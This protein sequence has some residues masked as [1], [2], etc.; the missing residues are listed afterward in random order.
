VRPLGVTMVH[1]ASIVKAI[2][3]ASATVLRG[4]DLSL[5]T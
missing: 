5:P 3:V 2:G 1:V 4:V